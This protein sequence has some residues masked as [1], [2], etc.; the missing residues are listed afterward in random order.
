[1]TRREGFATVAGPARE[2]G[3]RLRVVIYDPSGRGGVCQYTYNLAQ[4]LAGQGA[5]VTVLAPDDYELMHLPRQF[6]LKLLFK[7]SRTKAF[8]QRLRRRPAETRKTERSEGQASE[9]REGQGSVGARIS[10]QL[11][12][13]R[14]R[15]IL[16]RVA[17]GLL[18]RRP[19]IFHVQWLVAREAEFSLL[20]VM[21][22]AGI[23]LVYTAHNLL[24]HGSPSSEVRTFFGRL[25]RLA[26]RVIVHAEQ[27]R[28]ELLESFGVDPAATAVIPHGSF[29]VF[30][31]DVTQ[32]A[33][34]RALGIA[35]GRRVILF[36]GLIKRYKGLEYLV[37][38][39]R[40]VRSQVEGATLVIAG[41]VAT[42]DPESGPYYEHLL[43]ELEGRADVRIFPEFVPLSRL[44]L[45]FAAA[46]VVALPYVKTYQSGVLL[47]AYGAG[48]PV[49]TTDTG[50]LGESVDQ[51]KSGYVV[52]TRD[53]VA[54]AEALVK[55]LEPPSNASRMGVYARELAESR[56]SWASVASRTVELYCELLSRGSRP[57]TALA[58][59]PVRAGDARKGDGLCPP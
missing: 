50:G 8:L 34:Q 48:R 47:W 28:E 2:P 23:P 17:A 12:A 59:E 24:P 22:W 31:T 15:L 6:Q 7:R 9:R 56:Y 39:F 49:V 19:D 20:R 51:G 26:D 45:F 1:M 11:R 25:Y 37:E 27:N 13:V 57:R 18:L 53:A 5:E 46:D 55:V 4:H 35:A 14:I 33:A 43:G 32:E 54:L 10:D 58:A 38:A 3:R 44:P 16:G 42:E 41:R 30:T 40:E 36:F 29:A 52:P 21:K